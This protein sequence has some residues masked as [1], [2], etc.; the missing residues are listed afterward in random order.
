MANNRDLNQK[1][2][3]LR[4]MQKVMKA[5]NMIASI[6]LRKLMAGLEPLL[7][8]EKNLE[9]MT[10]AL[11]AALGSSRPPLLRDEGKAGKIHLVLF[12]AD[13]GLCGAHNTSALK[14]LET[15]LHEHRDRKAEITCIGRKGAL[16][17][18][19][20]GYDVFHETEI[21]S[22][23]LESGD[24][25]E[26]SGRLFRRYREGKIDALYQIGGRFVSTLQ[27]TVL[28][29][30]L[31]PPALPKGAPPVKTVLDT[32]VEPEPEAFLPGALEVH[33]GQHLEAA[34]AHSRLS[35]EAARMTAMENATDNSADLI[36]RYRT[37]QNR[38]RQA[39]ITNEIIEI[40]SG[41]EALKG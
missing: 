41:K 18:R 21:G 15:F 28:P 24:L 27:Q 22:R 34:L 36:D 14:A 33:L 31:L 10:A 32:E 19:R 17:C 37:M 7:L 12:T 39:S 11:L 9:A 6:K 26:L 3:S 29:R 25:Q 2:S 4:N 23:A 8:F 35:E 38:A 20:R 16:Y 40:V 30:R 5:M 13:K 1:I